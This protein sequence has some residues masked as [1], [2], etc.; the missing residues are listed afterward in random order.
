[1]RDKINKKLY[2]AVK[3][4]DITAVLEA[5]TEG[6]NPDQ[7]YTTKNGDEY[8]PLLLAIGNGNKEMVQLLITH[9]AN[10][11]TEGGVGFN[12]A[13][14]YGDLSIVECLIDHKILE[15]PFGTPL[16]SLGLSITEAAIHNHLDVVKYLFEQGI[17][18]PINKDR[19][20]EICQSEGLHDMLEYFKVTHG[21]NIGA[22]KKPAAPTYG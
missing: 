9:G 10:V 7:Y 16:Q 12:L 3:A 21:V 13:A 17:A 15:G 8:F 5:L 2:K 14:R 19:M 20:L 11:S 18:M 1:M 6:A 22:I 4:N